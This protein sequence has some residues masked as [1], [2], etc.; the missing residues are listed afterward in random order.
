M[1]LVL[2][3]RVLMQACCSG[4]GVGSCHRHPGPCRCHWR[5]PYP[6]SGFHQAGVGPDEQLTLVRV[7]RVATVF[8][9]ATLNTT[10]V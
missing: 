10:A 9:T 4:T 7:A 5:R 3:M 8:P 1:I 6:L 2:E